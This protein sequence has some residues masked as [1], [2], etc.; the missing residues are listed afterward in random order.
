MD[1]RGRTTTYSPEVRA[2]AVRTVLDHRGAYDAQGAAISSIAATT[3]CR[4]GA[5]RNRVRQAERPPSRP[6]DSGA[7]LTRR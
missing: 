6:I 1:E 5:L 7:P 3:G 4:G 2:R